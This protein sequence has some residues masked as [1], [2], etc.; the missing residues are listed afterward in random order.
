MPLHE[1]YFEREIVLL[2]LIIGYL[3]GY[4]RYKTPI[5]IQKSALIYR[6]VPKASLINFATVYD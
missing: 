5:F 2:A 4:I 6:T 1:G 3:R